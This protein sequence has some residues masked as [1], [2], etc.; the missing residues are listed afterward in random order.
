[1]VAVMAD[2][3]AVLRLMAERRAGQKVETRVDYMVEWFEMVVSRVEMMAELTNL[4]SHFAWK[5]AR[6]ILKELG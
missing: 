5:M 3:M 1:M 2:S 6:L 4:G